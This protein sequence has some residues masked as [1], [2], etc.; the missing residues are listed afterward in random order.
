MNAAWLLLMIC[1]G[2]PSNPPPNT[3]SKRVTT[4]DVNAT[5]ELLPIDQKKSSDQAIELTVGLR[6]IGAGELW[7]NGRM[8]LNTPYAPKY[9][10]ELWFDVVGPGNQR[11]EFAC[12]VRAGNAKPSDYR[13]LMPQE[14][15]QVQ[16][17]LSGCFDFT[18]P[19]T[20]L[21]RAKY[22]DGSEDVPPSPPGAM[23]LSTCLESSPAKIEIASSQ[24]N[25]R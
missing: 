9:M 4:S 20:Y 3:G 8:L 11:I 2:C 19:G 12:K 23:H 1:F 22:Q 14:S 18:L 13:V 7:V 5:L 24:G 21:I 10:R 25:S 15:K 17:R 16:V 6:N